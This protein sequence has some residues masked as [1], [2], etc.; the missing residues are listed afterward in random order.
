MNEHRIG[1]EV[2]SQVGGGEVHATA[3][4]VKTMKQEEGQGSAKTQLG[5]QNARKNVVRHGLHRQLHTQMESLVRFPC[6]VTSQSHRQRA[7]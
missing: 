4:E 6:C 7:P 1:E 5:E 3:V 2:R